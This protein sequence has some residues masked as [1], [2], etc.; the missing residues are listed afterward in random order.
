MFVCQSNDC[1][2]TVP[3]RTP[4]NR[5]VLETRYQVYSNKIITGKEKGNFKRTEG[6]EIVRQVSVCPG[7]YKKITGETPA[8]TRPAPAPFIIEDL[9]PRRPHKKNQW[10]NPRRQGKYADKQT[11]R[12]K[13]IV[14]VINRLP[15]NNVK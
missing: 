3:S 13:P 1:R 8:A 5:I 7:C 14:E 12:K 6:T 10:K 2:A 11:E 4:E 15:A 9:T